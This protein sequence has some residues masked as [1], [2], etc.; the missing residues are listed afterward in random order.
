MD[1]T[2]TVVIIYATQVLIP[3]CIIILVT[4][5]FLYSGYDGGRKRG[6]VQ[7]EE[8]MRMDRA[9][10]RMENIIHNFNDKFHL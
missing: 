2:C 3:V 10:V 8:E 5:P 9:A 1:M 6:M 4:V 7:R